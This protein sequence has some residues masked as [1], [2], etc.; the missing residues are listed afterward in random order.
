MLEYDYEII[1]RRGSL[2]YAP[3]ALSR[4]SEILNSVASTLAIIGEKEKSKQNDVK[5]EW[6]KHKVRQI[7]NKPLENPN[8][9]IRNYQLYFFRPDPLKS[10]LD[11][12]SN[13]WKLTIP[14]KLSEQVL[15][16][17]HDSK[18][19]GHF[20]MEKTYATIT[21][22]YFGPGMYSETLKYVKECDTCQKSKPKTNNQEG[23]LGKRIIEEPWTV[24]AADIICPL[25]RSKSKNQYIL[26]FVDM[27]TKWIEIIPVK[28]KL[29]TT[30]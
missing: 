17:N 23:L 30:I 9:R 7:K 6:Y 12:D 5:D 25:P 27:F 4:T 18:Q 10:S 29:A 1:Y 19:A 26:V 16:E 13:P 22:N 20:G 3:D 28:N 24:V 21:E 8:W 15:R 14:K 2:N 11:L